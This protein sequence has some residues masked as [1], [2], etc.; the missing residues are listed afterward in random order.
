M[1]RILQ[2]V[3]L[4]LAMVVSV[5]NAKDKD[6]PPVFQAK[7]IGF[8][9]VPAVST[10]AEG[11]FRAVIVSDTRIDFTLTYH[12]LEGNVTQAHIHF[13]Q[14]GVVGGISLWFCGTATNPGPA[15]TQTCPQTAEGLSAV[16]GTLTPAN[17]VGPAAQ[18]INEAGSTPAAEFAQILKAI[19]A[20]ITYANV[21][22]SKVPGGEIRGHIK[23]FVGKTD[24]DDDDDED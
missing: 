9:E 24:D 3:I 7:L 8:Q 23:L 16:T 13:G 5:A 19:R 11:K 22:T 18:L 17:I 15:G 20:G 6:K 14:R 12:G 2:S 21:H 1:K 4:L 10:V